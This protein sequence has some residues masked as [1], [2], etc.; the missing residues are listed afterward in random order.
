MYIV[1]LLHK[2]GLIIKKRSIDF[3]HNLKREIYYYPK[4]YDGSHKTHEQK[5]DAEKDNDE[6]TG[7][8]DVQPKQDIV[9]SEQSIST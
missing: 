5:N 8:R 1:G 3:F 7:I 2:W 6:F 4:K 9:V